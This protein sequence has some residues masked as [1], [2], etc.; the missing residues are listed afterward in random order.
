MRPKNFSVDV[1]IDKLLQSKGDDI[2]DC[3]PEGMG[4]LEL[5]K[6]EQNLIFM[7]IFKCDQCGYWLNLEDEADQDGDYPGYCKSCAGED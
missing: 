6:S 3:L 2:K 1:L 4:E 5:T 7:L